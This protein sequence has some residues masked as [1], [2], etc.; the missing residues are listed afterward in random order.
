MPFNKLDDSI[1]G[2]IRPRF[3]LE[4]PLSKQEIMDLILSESEKDPSVRSK[5]YMHYIK[6]R[7]PAEE[8]HYWSPVLSMSFEEENEKTV[9]RG[10]IGPNERVWSMF[11]FFYI[12]VTAIG[13]FGGMFGFLHCK[14]NDDPTWTFILPLSLILLTSIFFTSRYGKVKAHTQM[15]H[16]LRFLRRAV[17]SVECY[18]VDI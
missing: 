2:K 5:T 12:G 15:L 3:R 1:P 8:Q 18:R 6:L 16:L 7:C 10:I 4:T 13:F 14:Y 9:I 17:D 11:M